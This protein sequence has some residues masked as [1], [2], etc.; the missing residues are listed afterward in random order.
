MKKEIDAKNLVQFRL[1]GTPDGNLLVSFYQL[2]V[3][4]EQAINWHIAG[5][6][7]ENKLGARVLYEGNLSNNT[8]YQTAISNLLERVNVYVNCVRIA[9][10]H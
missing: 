5:L 2:D 4:N 10:V 6:L 9:K 1:T 3:F 8:A 7:V